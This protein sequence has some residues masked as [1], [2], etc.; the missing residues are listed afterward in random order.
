MESSIQ[1]NNNKEKTLVD[2]YYIYIVRGGVHPQ[3]NESIHIYSRKFIQC[4]HTRL[5]FKNT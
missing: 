2:P 4:K 5:A 3:Y 1:F